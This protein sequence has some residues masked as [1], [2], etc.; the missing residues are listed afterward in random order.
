ME[1]LNAE[2][3]QILPNFKAIHVGF[4]TDVA[5]FRD[6]IYILIFLSLP[7]GI[8]DGWPSWFWK[9]PLGQDSHEAASRETVQAVG[10]R[11]AARMYDCQSNLHSPLSCFIFTF[12]DDVQ[13][14]TS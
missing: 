8:V 4:L 9:E 13:F 2:F 7:P 10:H 14:L 5:I 11:G 3:N 6:R 1:R 12:K